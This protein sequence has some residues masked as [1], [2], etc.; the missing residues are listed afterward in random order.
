MELQENLETAIV[1]RG[2]CKEYEKDQKIL[3]ELNMTVIKGSMWV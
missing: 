2:A 1:I 3:D